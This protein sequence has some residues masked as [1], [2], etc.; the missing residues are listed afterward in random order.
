MDLLFNFRVVKDFCI[1]VGGESFE[2]GPVKSLIMICLGLLFA[3]N[4]PLI[5]AVIGG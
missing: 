5:K 3:V 2:V 1:F 4:E